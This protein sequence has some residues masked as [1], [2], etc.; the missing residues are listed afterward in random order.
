MGVTVALSHAVSVDGA[1]NVIYDEL[2]REMEEFYRDGPQ[3]DA[4]TPL[5]QAAEDD[6][7]DVIKALAAM[8]ADVNEPDEDGQTP[9]MA[10]ASF[11]NADACRTLVQDCG[12]EVDARDQVGDTALHEAAREGDVEVV[13]TLLYDCDARLDV[14]NKLGCT[15]LHIASHAG[16]TSV[17]KALVKAGA[18]VKGLGSEMAGGYSALHVAAANGSNSCLQALLENGAEIRHSASE[19]EL[20]NTGGTALEVAEANN[21]QEA[22]KILRNASTEEFEKFG[23]W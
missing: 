12:A 6:D 17:V 1:K 9:L 18:A 20:S 15:P 7:E 3:Y 2:K 13:K 10:A 4:A 14:R 22:C 11:G 21:Q 16:H 19:G 8:G 5:H 23:M